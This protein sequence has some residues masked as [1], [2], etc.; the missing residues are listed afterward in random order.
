MAHPGQRYKYDDEIFQPFGSTASHRIGP[1]RSVSSHRNPEIRPKPRLHPSIPMS[2][3]ARKGPAKVSGIYL[4]GPGSS[5]SFPQQALT[6]TPYGKTC[7]MIGHRFRLECAQLTRHEPFL[8][9]NHL[10]DRHITAK[11]TCNEQGD[12]ELYRVSISRRFNDMNE[13]VHTSNGHR[14][15]INAHSCFLG[16]GPVPRLRLVCGVL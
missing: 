4:V 6:T 14:R 11:F 1:H 15:R 2:E 9:I 13:R 5:Q 7:S 12:Q 3:L 8:R 10:T 16:G